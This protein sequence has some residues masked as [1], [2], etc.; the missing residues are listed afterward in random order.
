MRSYLH[1]LAQEAFFFDDETW[2]VLGVHHVPGSGTVCPPHKFGVVDGPPPPH[3]DRVHVEAIPED[4]EYIGFPAFKFVFSFDPALGKLRGGNDDQTVPGSDE[5]K[6]VKRLREL[7]AGLTHPTAAAA[8]V[9]VCPSGKCC[10]LSALTRGTRHFSKGAHGHVC[11]LLRLLE[12]KQQV[13]P[14]LA[15]P[16]GRRNHRGGM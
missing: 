6:L 15:R 5:A 8:A 1:L 3:S 16:C 10:C 13:L 12:R 11:G 14:P 9:H 4:A 7:E 2:Q